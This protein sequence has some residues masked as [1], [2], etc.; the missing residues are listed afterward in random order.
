[1]GAGHSPS[2][3]QAMPSANP[4]SDCEKTTADPDT[5]SNDVNSDPEA[6]ARVSS[7]PSYS[8]FTRGT[9]R[10]VVMMTAIGGVVSPMTA[11]IYFPALNPIAA[12]L[13]VS[14]GLINLTL[15][16]YMVLQAIA[17]PIFGDFSDTAGRRPAF[18]ISF[19]IYIVAN[20]GLSLQRNYAALLVLRM[21][22]SAGSSGTL[23]LCFAVIADLSVSAERGKYMAILGAGINVGPALSPV[24]GGILAEYLGWKAIFWFCLI[25]S[26]AWLVPFVLA[27]PET[28]RNVVGNG[29]IPAT[30]WNMTLLQYIR[31]RR[32]PPSQS[33]M[34][35]SIPKPPLRFPNPF[36]ALKAV[37]QKDLAMLYLY[38]TLVYLVF[39]LICA[40]VSTEFAAI[41]G[42]NDLTIGLCYL[43]YG[44]GCCSAAVFQGYVLD[45]NYRRIARSIGLTIDYRR[46]DDMS[47]FP[48]EKA[49]IQ[50]VVP[51]LIL[52]IVSTICYGW[53]LQAETHVAG[54]LVLLYIIGLCVTGSFSILNTIVVDLYPEAPATA[55]AANN[56]VRCLFGAGGTAVIEPMLKALGRGWTFTFWAL[57]LVVFSPMLYILTRIGPRCREERRLKRMEDG[58]S[59]SSNDSADN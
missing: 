46:G 55:I 3:D 16:T 54:P 13:G 18:I 57:I 53:T 14:I 5:A 34:Q 58:G 15:T 39:I 2:M 38:G 52:G 10:F 31:S 37:L 59:S 24:L 44:L 48:I 33:D 47:K 28:G 56:L 42:Y 22:Q 45:W 17:P 1:M 25:F 4:G 26:C 50:P 20:L 23:A 49:R 6:L 35:Q 8:V 11:N 7:S 27:V 36:N 41:Y 30:G 43:P 40:T 12:D 32:C 19:S 21:L 29:S 51:V 9:R